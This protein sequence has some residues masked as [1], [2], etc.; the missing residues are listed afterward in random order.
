MRNKEYDKLSTH[1]SDIQRERDAAQQE[2]LKLREQLQRNQ[3]QDF[4]DI[5]YLQAS[6]DTKQAAIN[7]L[8]EDLAKHKN[9]VRFQ[10]GRHEHYK[11]LAEESRKRNANLQR[12]L[13]KACADV[14]EW[15]TE[16]ERMEKA[17]A[18]LNKTPNQPNY[19]KTKGWYKDKYQGKK[20]AHW[21]TRG[22]AA[23]THL[24]WLAAQSFQSAEYASDVIK[25]CH[26]EAEMGIN[27]QPIGD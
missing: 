27:K 22:A 23:R 10:T 17:N 24:E 19:G 2:V 4:K 14:D 5:E 18:N 11:K 13:E 16:V 26:K 25:Q 9:E 7:G 15:R 6:V 8:E 12:A 20:V 3:A 1:K 21:A